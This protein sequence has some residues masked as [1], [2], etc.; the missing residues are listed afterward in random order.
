[1]TRFTRWQAL[2]KAGRWD[3][4]LHLAALLNIDNGINRAKRAILSSSPPLIARILHIILWVIIILLATFVILMLGS[5]LYTQFSDDWS[6]FVTAT[7][8]A[9]GGQVPSRSEVVAGSIIAAIM[10]GAYLYIALVVKAIVKT[11]LNGDP[12]VE[13]NIS[14]LRKTWIIIA[15]LEIFRMISMQHI[16]G[17]P[18][19]AVPALNN[20]SLAT[21][22]PVWFLV[23]VIA[24]MAEVFRIGL[25]LRRDQELTV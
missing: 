12:F 2:R 5:A 3:T 22:L 13:T 15:V 23:F 14:R 25:E 21:N 4:G 19:G 16:P 9:T 20:F 10:A 7:L 8:E 18:S 11:T 24:A 1:M 17:A 6:K